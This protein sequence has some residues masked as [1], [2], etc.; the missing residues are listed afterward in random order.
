MR[1]E[2][3]IKPTND[4][5][6]QDNTPTG[7][8]KSA[9]KHESA[10]RGKVYLVGAGPADP[11][12]ITVKGLRCLRVA[13]VVIYDSLV[14]PQLLEEAHPQAE[15]VYVGKR[16]GHHCMKQEQINA[17]LIQYAQQ[18]RIV[19]RLKGG[20]PFVF[21]RGGEEALALAQAGTSFE[22][23]PGVSSAIAVPAYAGIPVTHRHLA[24]SVTI[25]TGHEDAAHTSSRVDWEALAKL[26]GTLVIL[27]GVATLA[28]I[29]ERLRN[30]GLH[31]DT[32]AAVIQEGT[33]PEQ[34]VVTGTLETIADRAASAGIT[35][36]A[37]VVIGAVVT[38]HE[39]LTWYEG[40]RE[41][42]HPSAGAG[43][44]L[45]ASSGVEAFPTL[46]GERDFAHTGKVTV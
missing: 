43:I 22:I 34:H 14:S 36:P 17:L 23:V 42:S 15:R 40:V 39:A 30:G 38:L 9:L 2:Q 35:S 41:A 46:E 21:G 16:A 44:G 4:E 26:D 32:P 33:A 8:D 31:P 29:A 10:S 19:V 7:A 6:I 5:F 45:I 12:L 20:D 28:H 24:S 25:V 37:V 13:D 1:K 3:L 18:G 27:M 11:D